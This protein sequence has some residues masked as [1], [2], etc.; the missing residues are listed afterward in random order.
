MAD[1]GHSASRDGIRVPED[2]KRDIWDIL[3]WQQQ[4]L[5][6]VVQR[7]D[8]A[9]RLREILSAAG[10]SSPGFPAMPPRR[11]KRDRHGMRVIPGGLAALIVAPLGWL[12]RPAARRTAAAALAV[13]V[14]G[15]T[16]AGD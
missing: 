7:V 1:D 5:E 6:E 8:D 13:A 16:G 11:R 15:A 9:V 12:L 2:R 3:A 4:Q 10:S 14:G